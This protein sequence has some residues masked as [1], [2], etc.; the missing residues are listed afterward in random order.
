MEGINGPLEIARLI[1]FAENEISKAAEGEG[2]EYKPRVAYVEFRQTIIDRIGG[3]DRDTV[4]DVVFGLLLMALKQ[5][6]DAL[7]SVLVA[8]PTQRN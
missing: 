2:D 4:N 5:Q 1:Q 6:Y 3:V 8:E 7:A